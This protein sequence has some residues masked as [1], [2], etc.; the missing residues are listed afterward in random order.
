MADWR[1]KENNRKTVAHDQGQNG[2]QK[3]DNKLA[4]ESVGVA[5]NLAATAALFATPSVGAV[6][7]V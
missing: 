7:G 4:D 5:H 3:L 2:D 6:T 1:I